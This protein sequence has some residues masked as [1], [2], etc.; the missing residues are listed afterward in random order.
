[1][2]KRKLQ[3]N[4]DGGSVRIN[5]TD[6]EYAKLAW[7]RVGNHPANTIEAHAMLHRTLIEDMLVSWGLTDKTGKE[8]N[9]MA[10]NMQL[11]LS[12]ASYYLDKLYEEE[13]KSN[14]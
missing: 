10:W 11:E 12:N 14:D 5:L 3:T 2:T 6:K 8:I 1:M 7:K 9:G 4:R 13:E